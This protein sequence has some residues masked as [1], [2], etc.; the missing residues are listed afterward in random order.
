[1]GTSTLESQSSSSWDSL[2]RQRMRRFLWV[3]LEMY[4]IMV[5]GN[6]ISLAI[7]CDVHVLISEKPLQCQHLLLIIHCPQD[8]GES[9]RGHKSISYMEFKSISST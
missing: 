7:S 5:T 6:I 8:A 3:V 9:H 1:M 4:L 2:E